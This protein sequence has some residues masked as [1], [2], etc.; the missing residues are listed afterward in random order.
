MLQNIKSVLV[1][2]TEEGSEKPSSALAYGLSLAQ[3]AGAHATIQAA[4]IKVVVGNTF[5]SSLAGDLVAAHN[6]KLREAATALAER[7]RGEALAAGITCSVES[8][9]YTY[10]QLVS[11]FVAQ[12][13]V[14]DIAVVDGESE[15]INTDRG[16]IE[17]LLMD[18]GRPLIVVPAGVQAFS[19]RRVV[20]AWDGSARAA[21]AAGDALPL[22]RSAG[23]V[24][25]VA[26]G[27]EKELEKTVPGADL[28]PHLARHGVNV[29]L[30]NVVVQ[31]GIAETLREQVSLANA[32]LMVMGAFKHSVLREWALG[33]VT[34]SLLRESKVP[35]FM[36]Y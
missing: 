7:A 28:A 25:L 9:Q 27:T 33:G 32:D 4:T 17:A 26:V 8:P 30:K 24:T 12:A 5:V 34:Q 13:R 21:R 1:G 6:R 35:L 16:L 11:A 3:Q 2:V 19:K 22:L 29:T 31:D 20:V 14:H 23:A 15:A 36:S 18:S 10:G